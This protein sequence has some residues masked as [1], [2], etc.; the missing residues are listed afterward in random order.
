MRDVPL[1]VLADATLDDVPEARVVLVDAMIPEYGGNLFNIEPVRKRVSINF[2]DICD[3]LAMDWLVRGQDF[4]FHLAGQVSH[5]KSLTDP[6]P[7]DSLA[8]L[9]LAVERAALVAAAAAIATPT[10]LVAVAWAAV[11]I[12]IAWGVWVTVQKASVIFTQ[13]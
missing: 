7:E 13:G 10:W 2:G 4:V 3:R 5:V 1:Q 9:Y 12:P 11:G 8:S 6:F